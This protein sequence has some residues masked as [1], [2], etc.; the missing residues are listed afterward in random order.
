MAEI[1]LD[2]ASHCSQSIM[3]STKLKYCMGKTQKIKIKLT[4]RNISKKL[5]DEVLLSL[6]D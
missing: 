2:P 5:S 6:Q 1:K 3:S 4:L